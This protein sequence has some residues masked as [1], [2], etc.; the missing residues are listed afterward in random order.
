M[1]ILYFAKYEIPLVGRRGRQAEP[2]MKNFSQTYFAT[3][4][5]LIV[6]TVDALC[7]LPRDIILIEKYYYNY[8]SGYYTLII[9]GAIRDV[10][11]VVSR[12]IKYANAKLLFKGGF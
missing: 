5:S 6:N 1:S 8:E 7:A 12:C 2:W 10:G 11:W 4:I 3:Q 9:V